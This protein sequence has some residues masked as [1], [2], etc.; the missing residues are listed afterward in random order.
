M[1]DEQSLL[2]L[3]TWLALTSDKRELGVKSIIVANKSDLG[4]EKNDLIMK[5]RELAERYQ[6]SFTLISAL[7]IDQVQTTF[8][9]FVDQFKNTGGTALELSSNKGSIQRQGGIIRLS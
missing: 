8:E 4:S 1:D 7:A 3:R 2:G 6:V 5:G 9:S